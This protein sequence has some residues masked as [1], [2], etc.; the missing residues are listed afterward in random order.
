M[1]NWL[2]ACKIPKKGGPKLTVFQVTFTLQD[3]YG[4]KTR[5]RYETEDISGADIGAEFLLAHTAAGD[6][7]TDLSNLTEAE[8]LYYTVGTEVTATD[9]VVAEANIDEG[10]TMTVTKPDN[11]RGT[12]KVPAPIN[13]VFNADGTVDLTDAAITAYIANFQSGGDF[14]FSDGEKVDVLVSGKLDK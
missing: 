5:K 11:K 12:L 1:V 7:F 14:T 4:R 9:S 10:L 3:A 2:G 6:L 8:V 13:A